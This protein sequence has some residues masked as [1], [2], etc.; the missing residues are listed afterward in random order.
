[1]EA[2]LKAVREGGDIN[3]WDW[4]MRLRFLGRRVVRFRP[5]RHVAWTVG[6]VF[7]ALFFADILLRLSAEAL[8]QKI[9]NWPE[10]IRARAL[11]EENTRRQEA[12]SFLKNLQ[13]RR[14]DWAGKVADLSW[15]VPWQVWLN[16]L[17]LSSVGA[18]RDGYNFLLEGG[19]ISNSS[20][21]SFLARL[22][23]TSWVEEARLS[24]SRLQKEQ[25]KDLWS[26]EI[27]VRTRE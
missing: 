24:Y 14:T 17:S 22:E 5:E 8:E 6:L 3:F 19:S 11:V 21:V 13:S 15:K 27:Q 2:R 25:G 20:I 7:A 16:R 4:R 12:V 23:K 9:R 1:M 26:Y 18:S 10:L